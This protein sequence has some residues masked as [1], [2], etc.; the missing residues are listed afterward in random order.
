M[1]IPIRTVAI[2]PYTIDA[3]LSRLA[4][5]VQ[6]LTFIYS[7]TFSIRIAVLYIYIYI[8]VITICACS[9]MLPIELPNGFFQLTSSIVAP[10]SLM[11][12]LQQAQFPNI[13]VDLFTLHTHTDA[14]TRMYTY[15]CICVR[16]LLCPHCYQLLVIRRAERADCHALCARQGGSAGPVARTLYLSF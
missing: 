2:T 8:Y 14:G 7:R 6:R 10:I 5:L 1:P 15:I 4:R 11:A 16:K 3:Q 13:S 9:Y 12:T